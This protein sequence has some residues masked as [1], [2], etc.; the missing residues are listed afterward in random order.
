[1]AIQ[2]AA[3]LRQ[4]Y[5]ITTFSLVV[6]V[7]S[8]LGCLGPVYDKEKGE[9]QRLNGFILSAK[10]FYFV[11][12]RY[13]KSLTELKEKCPDVPAF[14]DEWGNKLS[15]IVTNK[16]TGCRFTSAGKD[17]QFDTDDD[18][19]ASLVSENKTHKPE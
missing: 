8:S 15:Y 17:G 3:N 7:L 19:L 4:G 11:N 9:K 14:T 1:M 16:G 10:T 6:L 2:L 18:L 12:Q 13:P 5:I